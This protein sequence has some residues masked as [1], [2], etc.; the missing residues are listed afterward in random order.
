MSLVQRFKKNIQTLEQTAQGVIDLDY[1]NPKLYKKVLRFYEDQGV[2]FYDD[3]YDTYELIVD[4]LKEDL[5]KVKS[6]A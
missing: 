6:E 5:Q 4:L 3:P 2:E 1:K